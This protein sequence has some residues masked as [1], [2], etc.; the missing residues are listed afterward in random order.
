[1]DQYKNLGKPQLGVLCAALVNAL[2][3]GYG[4]FG[5]R[6]SPGCC[7][8]IIYKASFEEFGLFSLQHSGPSMQADR[9]ITLLEA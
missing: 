7:Q 2:Q 4:G 9:S 8:S 3:E 5:R 1:M 6:D